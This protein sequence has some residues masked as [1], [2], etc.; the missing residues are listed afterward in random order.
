MGRHSDKKLEMEKS[1]KNFQMPFRMHINAE[2]VDVVYLVCCII[3]ETVNQIK[4]LKNV[5]SKSQFQNIFDNQSQIIFL[6]SNDLSKDKII[7]AMIAV[8]QGNCS[9]AIF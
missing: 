4:S 3:L 8:L 1:D 6:F 5:V 9:E 7:A 2:L